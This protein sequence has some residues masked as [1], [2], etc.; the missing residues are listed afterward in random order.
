MLLAL[1]CSQTQAPWA[2]ATQSQASK[3]WI[4]LQSQPTP[5]TRHLCTVCNLHSCMW[6]LWE[7]GLCSFPEQAE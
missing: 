1:W 6:Q 3:T 5:L 4:G 7:F 2:K